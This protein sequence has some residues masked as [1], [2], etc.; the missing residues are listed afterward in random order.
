MCVCVCV[1]YDWP[2]FSNTSCISFHCCGRAHAI[3]EFILTSIPI[4]RLT[5]WLIMTSKHTTQHD[6]ISTSTWEE[7]REKKREEKIEIFGGLKLT[8]SF[9]NITRTCTTTILRHKGGRSKDNRTWTHRYY[10]SSKTMS[11]ICTLNDCTQ[12]RIT[13]TSLLSSSTHRALSWEGI[14]KEWSKHNLPG[15]IP[16]LIMSAPLKISS[17]TIS[18]VTTL[19]ALK[20]MVAY[21]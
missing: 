12:L 19:P 4:N 3:K 15:P 8:K 11:S 7:K 10:M 16:T 13:Y 20:I 2:V 21:S 17:S 9:G 14:R 1:C 5:P 6:K 18:P